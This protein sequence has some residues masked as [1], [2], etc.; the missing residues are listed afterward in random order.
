MPL[1]VSLLRSNVNRKVPLA[2]GPPGCAAAG[3]EGL[4]A[5]EGLPGGLSGWKEYRA[6]QVA[7]IT[8]DYGIRLLQLSPA[9]ESLES[10][11]AYLLAA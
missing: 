11:F 5:S 4:E 9:D 1:P 7:A 8:R 2:T 6:D 3:A 10:V